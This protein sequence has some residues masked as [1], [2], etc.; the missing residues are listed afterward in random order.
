[1]TNGVV[2]SSGGLQHNL[3]GLF[4]WKATYSGDALNNSAASSC[5]AI[6]VNKAQPTLVLTQSPSPVNIGEELTITLTLTGAASTPTG[7]ATL[8]SYTDSSCTLAQPGVPVY[9]TSLVNGAIP[10]PAPIVYNAAG[11]VY[12]KATYS[13]DANN[14]AASTSCQAI[15]IARGL[16]LTVTV[17]PAAPILVGQ[18]TSVRASWPASDTPTGTVTYALYSGTACSGGVIANPNTFAIASNSVPP[19]SSVLLSQA[20]DYSWRVSYSGGGL[21]NP[22]TRCTAFIAKATPELSIEAIPPVPVVGQDLIGRA[23]LS[24]DAYRPTGTVT[25]AVYLDS[26]CTVLFSGV[27]PQTKPLVDGQVPDSD[28]IPIIY[29]G[30][31]YGHAAYSGD[32][33][34]QP[35]SSACLQAISA[36]GPITASVSSASLTTLGYSNTASTSTGQIVIAINDRRGTLAGWS[37]T[38]TVSD[39]DYA[40][41]SPAGSDI[42]NEQFAITA[43]AQPTVNS[44]QPIGAGGPAAGPNATGSLGVTRTVATARAGYGSG[45]YQQ[46]LEVALTIPPYSQAGTYVAT[47]VVATSAAP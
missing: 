14:L 12:R 26:S 15:V 44:G 41:V 4:Y 2:P 25:Y 39:F 34:N 38:I 36:P 37:A 20:G 46:V 22:V 16:A 29:S 5:V 10:S 42:P 30:T 27:Q 17:S 23:R 24:A 31:F 1:V 35:A 21:Y 3:A 11:T 19:S 9:T 40:G 13:G 43:A 28:P 18:S 8:A 6:T 32:A 33:Y 7:T 45:F 47:I